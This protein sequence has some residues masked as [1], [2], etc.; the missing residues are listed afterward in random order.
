VREVLEIDANVTAFA[1]FTVQ[2][3]RRKPRNARV[4]DFD[5]VLPLKET[6]PH[7]S[8]LRPNNPEGRNCAIRESLLE[9]PVKMP[10]NLSKLRGLGSTG[11]CNMS[12]SV[13]KH[14]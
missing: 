3:R 2:I 8:I 1:P 7:N 6:Q 11:D 4:A 9:V 12:I 5:H 10:G 14:R 13:K